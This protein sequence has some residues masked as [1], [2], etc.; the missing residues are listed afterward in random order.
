MKTARRAPVWWSQMYI[1]QDE[2][3]HEGVKELKVRIPVEQHLQLHGLK[4]MTGKQISDAV[5]EALESYFQVL[6]AEE[7]AGRVKA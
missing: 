4:V 2:S 3:G 5:T 7:Q 6:R 1:R